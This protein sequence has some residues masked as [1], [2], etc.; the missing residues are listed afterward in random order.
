MLEQKG[1]PLRVAFDGPMS[2]L[3]QIERLGPKWSEAISRVRAAGA[4]L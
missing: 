3:C 1:L 4:A 2:R